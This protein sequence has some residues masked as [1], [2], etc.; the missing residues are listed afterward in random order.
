LPKTDEEKA[1]YKAWVADGWKSGIA[2]GKAIFQADLARL[3]RDYQGMHLYME[4]LEQG[5]VSAPFVAATNQ[6]VTGDA[7]TLNID[8]VSLK[9]TVMPAFQQDSSKWTP[10]AK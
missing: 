1:K 4:L 2:Q 6:H 8:D 9:I 10:V 5:K 3:D 7:N